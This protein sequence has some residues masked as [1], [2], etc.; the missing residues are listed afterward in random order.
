MATTS[1]RSRALALSGLV[2]CATF[3]F[4]PPAATDPAAEPPASDIEAAVHVLATDRHLADG[5]VGVEVVDV[6]SGRILAARG[7]HQLLNPASNAK[8]YTAAAA[9]A[10]LHEQH[11]YQ[12]TLSG[13]AKNEA[14]T[15][16]L[17][18]RGHGDPSL[19]T[20]DL[21]SMARALRTSGIRRI[22]G[23]ILVEQSFFDESTT[24]PAFEQQ[25]HEWASFRAPVSA[26]AVDE[27][28]VTMTVR[29]TQP[30]SPAL[31]TFDPPGHVKVD[32][33]VKTA[34]GGADRVGLVLAADGPRLS[35]TVSGTVGGDTRVVRYTRRVDNPQLLAGDVLKS[36][37]E[38]VGVKVTG[39]VKFTTKASAPGAVLARHESE[40]LGTLLYALGKRSDNFYAEMIFKSISAEARARPGR[41]ATSAEM[42]GKW[43]AEV[44]ASDTGLVLK[45][46]SGLFDANRVTAH[47][48]AQLLRHAYRDPAIGPAFVSQLAIGGVDGTLRGR[49]RW[50]SGHHAVRAKTGTL[51]DAISLSG[52]VLGPPGKPP[53]AFAILFNKVSGKGSVARGAADRL[54]DILAKRQ[55][56]K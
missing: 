20:A 30:G 31:V 48:L 25:P 22:E 46:G 47:S 45:N 53:L 56:A 14:V 55:W 40:P 36:V 23:D 51:D 11:R 8:I 42:V 4:A 44:G 5:L 1:R 10:L 6:A 34:E 7:E 39:G 38:D 19:T 50:L 49:F 35:A 27:N 21:W 2:A 41:S 54:V 12:T 33:T 16:P 9:L 29:P 17:V 52:Y 13:T 28:T 18:L 3:A 24:P 37:L 32:G 26:V 43:L 15:G